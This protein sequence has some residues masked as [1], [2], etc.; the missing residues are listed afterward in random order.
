MDRRFALGDRGQGG[1]GGLV[2]KQ[3]YLSRRQVDH[4]RRRGGGREGGMGGSSRCFQSA[5]GWIGWIVLVALFASSAHAQDAAAT[6]PAP[7]PAPSKPA[8][9]GGKCFESLYTF[10]SVSGNG[11]CDGISFKM[12]R[13]A[14]SQAEADAIARNLVIEGISTEACYQFLEYYCTETIIGGAYPKLDAT[15]ELYCDRNFDVRLPFLPPSV[16]YHDSLLGASF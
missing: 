5:V 3:G 10:D 9:P 4:Y 11:T 15:C 6:T 12:H 2:R 16:N 14:E 1:K 7:D 13:C 8:G